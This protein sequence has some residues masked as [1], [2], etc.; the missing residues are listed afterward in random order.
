MPYYIQVHYP[1]NH[2]SPTP[3]TTLP[4]RFL[5]L[6]AANAE[7][8]YLAEVEFCIPN[9]EAAHCVRNGPG[10]PAEWCVGEAEWNVRLI[11]RVVFG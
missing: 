10:V 11:V 8:R 9:I 4:Q 1:P 7:A 6:D 3:P 2:S 5:T